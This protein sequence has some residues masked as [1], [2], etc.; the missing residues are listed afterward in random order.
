M[1]RGAGSS[2][3]DSVS[4]AVQGSRAGRADAVGP[5][6]RGQALVELALVAPLLILLLLGTAELGHAF[7]AYITLVNATREGAR[8]AARGNVHPPAVLLQ[9]VEE[10]SRQIDLQDATV[11][12]TT[13]VSDP[14]TFAVTS[15]TPR[16]AEPS[17]FTAH[18]LKILHRQA[19]DSD[20]DTPF[21]RRE[22]F[23]VLEVFYQHRTITG[24][25]GVTI[26]MY[27]YTI[28]KIAAA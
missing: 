8:L 6:E 22:Q 23:V 9:V 16:G 14:P 26:P 3:R 12:V 15:A 1:R 21:L 18:D 27:A 28:M 11:V 5:R 24:F 2:R 17:R 13:V 25:L 7:N 10:H 20:P 4:P 19:T